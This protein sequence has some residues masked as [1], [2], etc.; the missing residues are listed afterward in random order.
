VRPSSKELKE[1]IKIARSLGGSNVP[2]RISDGRM[3]AVGDAGTV[4]AEVSD[5]EPDELDVVVSLEMLKNV[6]LKEESARLELDGTRLAVT[7]GSTTVRLATQDPSVVT[8]L[9]VDTITDMSM[10]T[11]DGAALRAALKRVRAFVGGTSTPS[12]LQAVLLA[13]STGKVCTAD[14]M[15]F[16]MADLAGLGGL[17]ILLPPEVCAAATSFFG[18]ADAGDSPDIGICT[19]G[20]VC[21]MTFGTYYLRA[22]MCAGKFPGLQH[23]SAMKTTGTANVKYDDFAEAVEALAGIFGKGPTLVAVNFERGT[24]SVNTTEADAALDFNVTT[25]GNTI[26]SKRL[27]LNF[28]CRLVEQ[29]FSKDFVMSDL[30]PAYPLKFSGDGLELYVMPLR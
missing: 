12:H 21:Y 25:E 30:G 1:F 22:P 19:D 14:G 15:A 13:G 2:V 6:P 17:D 20:N 29:A 11:V 5:A 26:E 3:T 27:S 16:A 4:T 9:N 18:T 24:M 28:L 23:F 10:S 8:H 7:S